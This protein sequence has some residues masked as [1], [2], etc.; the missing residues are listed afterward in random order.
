MTVRSKGLTWGVAAFAAPVLFLVFILS[1]VAYVSNQDSDS[2]EGN[3]YRKGLAY[4]ERIDQLRRTA[5]LDSGLTVESHPESRMMSIRFPPSASTQEIS[6]E[7]RLVRPSDANLDE[8]WPLKP[9]SAGV[10]EFSIAGIAVGLWRIEVD[11]KID[12]L[13]YYYQS[14][15]VVP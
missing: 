4:Q 5:R 9:D 13:A 15:L 2:V 8:R 3:Y 6:G 11:W 1:L 14:R 10:Q 12:T 7:V